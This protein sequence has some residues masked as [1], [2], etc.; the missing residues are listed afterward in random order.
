MGQQL[1]VSISYPSNLIS[2]VPPPSL[3]LMLQTL[4]RFFLSDFQIYFI[5][6]S[7]L[8]A[9]ILLACFQQILL[10]YLSYSQHYLSYS[11]TTIILLQIH[12]RFLFIVQTIHSNFSIV[13]TDC[14]LIW[15]VSA[16]TVF[17]TR[18]D[19]LR[20]MNFSIFSILLKA[21]FMFSAFYLLS[22]LRDD[23]VSNLIRFCCECFYDY[24]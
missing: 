5:V 18:Q 12:S 8:F 15:F 9:S 16:E 23:C 6:C 24:R 4:S 3:C 22:L 11:Q 19:G 13:Q 21:N 1:I 14:F 20:L 2:R 7:L 17:N 10:H